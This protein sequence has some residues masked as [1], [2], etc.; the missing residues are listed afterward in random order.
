MM[1]VRVVWVMV[2][3]GLGRQSMA[4]PFPAPDIPNNCNSEER[5]CMPRPYVGK[6]VRQFEPDPALPMRV[7][8]PVHLLTSSEITRLERAYELQRALPE[9]DP[10][11]LFNQ[12]KL[13][14]QYCDNAY[15]YP[16]MSWPLEIH[17][18]WLFLP[19]HRMFMYFNERILA[20]LL[21]DD[22]FAIPYWNWDNQTPDAPLANT[23]P[24]IYAGNKSSSLY[25]RNRNVCAQPPYVVDLNSAGGCTTKESD[26]LR[27]Q[28]T[29]LMYTQIV[30]G[31][32]TANLFF[33]QAY[34]YG[35]SG[36]YGPGTL[37]DTPHGNVHLWVGS[38][39]AA[40]TFDDMGNFGR[41]ARDPLFFGH[42]G[43]I[44]RIWE[45][46]KTLNGTQRREPL[47]R[48]FL[49]AQF[50]FYDENAD[51]VIVNISQMLDTRVLRYE[52]E[53][54]PAEWMSIDSTI[55][56]CNPTNPS[57]T[58]AMILSIREL[59]ASDVFGDQPFT[60]RVPRGEQSEKG[61]EVLEIL[62]IELDANLQVHWEAYLFYPSADA[63]TSVSC[64]EFVG[65]Y[66]YIPHVG[67]AQIKIERSWRVALRS[68][69][70]TLGKQNYSEIVVTLAQFGPT[71]Q[72][73]RFGSARIF[74]DTSPDNSTA[75]A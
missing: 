12:A 56:Y 23:L 17:N 6:P 52:Y 19:Y 61:H 42:H 65:T 48:D 45:L 53:A 34:S 13:H 38:P 3:L 39:E 24:A 67:Q 11:R 51:L 25:D 2:I 35:D 64:P 21:G 14:C 71:I 15:T 10:R 37:E 28:N 59:N 57:Q 50:T 30:A 74:Y 41:S 18:N 20:N 43:N 32:P 16:G 62:G 7:R 68:K 5:C 29:R 46:W 70:V 58:R 63:T 1:D 9:S 60:F 33:G 49:D 40:T 72:S 66:N 75:V 4:V 8:R 22:T 73:L 26:E 36:G 69:L 44:D 47:E 27:I 54:A 31:S 55:P